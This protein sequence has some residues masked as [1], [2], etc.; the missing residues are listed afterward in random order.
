[1]TKAF[2]PRLYAYAS[3]VISIEPHSY[4]DR[5]KDD[6]GLKVSPEEL[7]ALLAKLAR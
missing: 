7:N 3:T 1:M 2:S 4:A 6:E 5:Q